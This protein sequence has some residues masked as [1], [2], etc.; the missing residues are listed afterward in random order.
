MSNVFG[1]LHTRERL[2]NEMIPVLL[3]ILDSDSENRDNI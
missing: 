1:S 2:L 3:D